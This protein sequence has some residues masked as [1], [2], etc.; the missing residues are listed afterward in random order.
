MRQLHPVRALVAPRPL[1]GVQLLHLV[2]NGRLSTADRR[3]PL[4]QA[5]ELPLETR[6]FGIRQVITD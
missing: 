3:G 6:D 4:S 2:A 1:H 5:G